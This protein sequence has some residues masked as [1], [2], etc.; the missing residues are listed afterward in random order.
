MKERLVAR[1]EKA[2]IK[3]VLTMGEIFSIGYGD[4]GSSIYYALGIT[5]L[6]ALGLTPIAIGLAGVVFL[7]TALSY[8]ELSAMYPESG[9]SASFARHA[10]NDTAS[11]VAGWGL[12]LDYIVTIAISA[13][14]ITPYLAVFYQPLKNVDVQ[15]SFTVGIIAF[16]FFINYFGVRRST[17]M[18]FALAI[19]AL[20]TQIVII[21]AGVIL[22]LDLPKV[23][24]HFKIGVPGVDWSPSWP[25][26]MRG[27]AMAMVAY[28]G[29]ESI[30]Q[31]GSE[32]R[33]PKRDLPRAIFFN[34]IALLTLYFGVSIVA[35]SALPPEVLG[36]QY[37]NDPLEGIVLAFPGGWTW[38]AKWVGLLAAALLFVASNAGLMGSSR[39]AYN[40]GQYYQLPQFFSALHPRYLV[41]ARSLGFFAILAILLVL[42]SGGRLGFLADLYNFGAMIAFFSTNVSLIVLR[43]KKKN[44]ERPYKIPFNIRIRGYDI[45]IS[46]VIGSFATLGVWCLIVITKPEGRYLGLGWLILGV[47][48][49]LFYRKRR[50]LPAAG[51]VHVKEVKVEKPTFPPVEQILVPIQT[52]ADQEMIYSAAKIAKTHNA[53]LTLIHVIEIPASLPLD[54]DVEQKIID[55]T[56]I[57]QYAEAILR[58]ENVNMEHFILR[59]R[60]FNQVLQETLKENRWQLVMLA[61]HHWDRE[62]TS[63]FQNQ[64]F[65]LW[66]YY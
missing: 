12:L 19:L 23:I 35:L 25:D 24:S 66:I 14:S 32:A 51:R 20:L 56:A 53:K 38:L 3:R 30:A 64:P 50:R 2:S 10:F 55:A 42:L 59:G 44:F 54:I 11:F 8:A 41:P 57:L 17:K 48:T 36:H 46:G 18:S 43:V 16:L 6:F 13:F 28:T 63:I 65:R 45:P 61:G 26:F 33:N 62:A 47:V 37:T 31:L 21:V 34:I 22:I 15:I 9:G 5:A 40:M 60:S 1:M 39:L 52:L 29:I 58:E 49:Y 4:L 7:C 27:V